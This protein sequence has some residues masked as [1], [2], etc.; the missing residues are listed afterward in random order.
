MDRK[1]RINWGTAIAL[2]AVLS[3]TVV[4]AARRPGA[5]GGGQGRRGAS[6][7]ADAPPDGLPTAVSVRESGA[8]GDG[9]TDD[10]AALQKA[11]DAAASAGRPLYVPA[12][13]YLVS[14]QLVLR[15]GTNLVGVPGLSVI[16]LKPGMSNRRLLTANG[17]RG[18][19]LRGLVLDAGH[20]PS[21]THASGE[22]TCLFAVRCDDFEVRD[23]EV[24]NARWY[25]LWFVECNGCR[26][27]DS[28]VHDC[29]HRGIFFTADQF[30][31]RDH[32]VA[33]NRV[34]R[35]DEFAPARPGAAAAA[36]AP[37]G[38]GIGSGIGFVGSTTGRQHK[39]ERFVIE[40]NLCHDNGRAGILVTGGQDFTISNNT[41][42]SNKTEP[43]LGKGIQLSEGAQWA[44]IEGNTC[45][46]NRSGID[47]DPLVEADGTW[48]QGRI[49]IRGNTCHGNTTHGIHVNHTPEVV[50]EDNTVY[51]N[52][53]GILL[54]AWGTE[55]C[56]VA[57]NTVTDNKTS[58]VGVSA[59]AAYKDKA[60][61]AHPAWVKDVVIRGN[62]LLR[63]GATNKPWHAGV[64]VTRGD[65]VHVYD[66]TFEKNVNRTY[67][68]EDSRDVK[69]EN[70]RFKD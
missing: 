53:Y 8:V 30:P 33:R 60:G 23:C 70:N 55:N 32:Y 26:V 36:A 11:I 5:A 59:P 54:T 28:D 14:A 46:D 44:T 47:I 4:S 48:G 50:V 42:Y 49:T 20:A 3:V 6:A 40:G 12:G 22:G 68:S 18:V 15:Q 61:R 35:I 31:A 38:K 34:W 2:L 19:R 63:N 29:G 62:R 24:R 45:F 66:N 39:I 9:R 65:G 57:D 41:C 37:V 27:T 13:T 69:I 51:E 7:A 1:T 25:G 64:V 52:D 67:Q 10:T 58:G 56:V 43:V 16:R 17:V 21:R